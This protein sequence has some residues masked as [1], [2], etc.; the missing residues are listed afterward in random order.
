[1]IIAQTIQRV[2]YRSIPQQKLLLQKRHV[3]RVKNVKIAL[4]MFIIVTFVYLDWQETM[5]KGV[6]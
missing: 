2:L 5:V 1:M 4:H 6:P 3:G